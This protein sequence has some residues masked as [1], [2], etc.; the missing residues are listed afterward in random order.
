MSF[1][2]RKSLRK[3]IL[4]AT[5][6]YSSSL[7]FGQAPDSRP[8]ILFVLSDDHSAAHIG[9]YG[10]KDV[11]TPNIDQLARDGIY[12]TRAYV[13]S[14]QCA[15]SRA[16]LMTGRSPVAL[17]M[18][19]FSAPLPTEFKVY[20]E[21][22]RAAG[23]YTGVAGRDY[24]LD[25]DLNAASE[26][27]FTERS[28]RTFP[29]RL[30]FVKKTKDREEMIAQYEEFLDQVPKGQPFCL[31]LSF[32]DPHRPYTPE[33]V[34]NPRDPATITLPDFYPDTEKVRAD[35]AA[36]YDEVNRFDFDLGRVLASLKKRGLE[37]NTIVVF[38]GD[39]GAAQFRGKGTL[40][41][42][43]IKVPLVIRWPGKV[44]PGSTSADLISGEDLAPTM[45]AAAGE[46][47]PADMTGVSFLPRLRA[48]PFAS[49]AYIYAERGAHGSALP[50]NTA[51]FDLG[52]TVVGP[53]HKLI[54]NAL[55]QLPYWPADFNRSLMWEELQDLNTAG[56][57]SPL[58][59]RLYF[60]PTRPMFEVYDLVNDP[61]E[62]NNL[63]GTPAIEQTENQLKQAL[64]EWMI[65]ERDYVPLP[66][67]RGPRKDAD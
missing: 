11:Q 29:S 43:G 17:D 25:G 4:T 64:H 6:L 13:T 34:P 47:V 55:W 53:T 51:P 45:L 31:Q 59:A 41:E 3:N 26:K 18:T 27:V 65:L 48:E 32:S 16:S 66:I 24:H 39:N 61:H 37:E 35:L 38:M 44:N 15:P 42:L 28:L 2:S 58:H 67:P 1:F 10:N 52:R 14:P 63:A 46:P 30:D 56:K 60:S 7:A 20:P 33:N 54:Y 21:Y 8:N 50:K 22:L 19:R 62:F 23:Y 5:F 12:F 36:Y 57:L 9:I 49:R 40:Y